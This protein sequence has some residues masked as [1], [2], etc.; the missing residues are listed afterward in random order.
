MLPAGPKPP[1][2]FIKGLPKGLVAEVVLGLFRQSLGAGLV[3]GGPADDMTGKTQGFH[4]HPAP[5][6]ILAL[7]GGNIVQPQQIPE[8]G[9][10]IDRGGD[11]LGI[12]PGVD[13]AETLDADHGP[14]QQPKPV[15]HPEHGQ[16]VAV[17]RAPDVDHV[18][19][20]GPELVRKLLLQIL[21]VPVDR[22]LREDIVGQ[23]PGCGTGGGLVP[24]AQ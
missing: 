12:V 20:V 7:L 4:L 17:F 23:V 18:R 21:L 1:L 6:D 14:V 15:A 11:P 16:G 9:A 5:L 8:G 22:R 2:S 19:L 3:P 10:P 24:P 13:G